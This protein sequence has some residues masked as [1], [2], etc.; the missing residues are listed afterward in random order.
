MADKKATMSAVN[1]LLAL[2]RAGD[3]AAMDKIWL[4]MG[5]EF[6]K[7]ARALLSKERHRTKFGTTGSGLVAELWMALVPRMEQMQTAAQLLEYGRQSMRNILCTYARERKAAKRD[8]GVKV[9]V[10]SPFMQHMESKLA[11]SGV[12][13]TNALDNLLDAMERLKAEDPMLAQVVEL[14]CLYG[15]S[16]VEASAIMGLSRPEYQRRW[17]QAIGELRRMLGV[18]EVAAKAAG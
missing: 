9:D 16:Q 8:G 12:A 7:V 10:E 11:S 17:A 2:A 18:T 1:Q 14:S 6:R 15:H 3:A 5:P 13:T 4:Q